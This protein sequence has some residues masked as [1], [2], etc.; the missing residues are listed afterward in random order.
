MEKTEKRFSEPELGSTKKLS[1]RERFRIKQTYQ[2]LQD[3]RDNTKG[4]V[5]CIPEIVKGKKKVPG[6]KKNIYKEL[7][8]ENLPS[9]AKDLK[10]TDS[11][12]VA[13]HKKDKL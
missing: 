1:N 3:L 2:S 9:L 7:M 13:Y 10:L 8:V 12:N 11:R 6:R 5:I 4:F